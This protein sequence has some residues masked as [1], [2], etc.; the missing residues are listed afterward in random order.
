MA[1][2]LNPNPFVGATVTGHAEDFQNPR[3]IQWGFA[4]EREIAQGLVVGFDFSNVKT[5]RVQRNRDLNLPAPL[6]GAEYVAFLQ[7]NNTAANF[8]TMT[9]NGTIS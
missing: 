7:A 3:S 1:L 4:V 5:D 2:G 8:T 9:N 6:T